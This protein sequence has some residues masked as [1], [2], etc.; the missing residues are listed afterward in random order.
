MTTTKSSTLDPA[1]VGKRAAEILDQMQAH[2]L[3]ERFTTSSMK[4]S[5]CWATYTGMPAISRFDLDRDGQ[6]LLVEAMRSLALKAAVYDLTGGDEQ[7]SELLLPLPV[8]DMVH[9]VLAQHTVMSHI[10]RDLGVLFPHDTALEDFAYFRGCDT[11]AYYAAAGWGE[12]PLR[13]WL[14]TAEVDKR[15]AHLNEL[16]GSVGITAGG[17]SHDIDFDTMFAAPAA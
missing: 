17:R 8:D 13:Y 4:Y 7:A 11:D 5:P 3:W 16:Y 12:Q 1:A 6:P 14:D 15:I 2:P 9:A 10:E